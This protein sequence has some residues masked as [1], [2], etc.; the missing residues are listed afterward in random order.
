M[1]TKTDWFAFSFVAEHGTCLFAFVRI[2]QL[3]RSHLNMKANII[4]LKIPEFSQNYRASN[5]IR[6]NIVK[7]IYFA[8]GWL[9]FFFHSSSSSHSTNLNC[10]SK[11][12]NTENRVS[13]EMFD[14]PFRLFELHTNCDVC[15]KMPSI[16]F[17][18]VIWIWQCIYTRCTTCTNISWNKKQLDYR[19]VILH[20]FKRL[21]SERKGFYFTKLYQNPA[22][23]EIQI[24]SCFHHSGLCLA[25][26]LVL[27][28]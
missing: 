6:W 4:G 21:F 11:R 20:G 17:E 12:R 3:K 7:S 13:F 19:I 2:C 15:V 23:N 18:F 10:T 28:M 8:N 1:E 27:F 24:C 16:E 14:L 5:G 22:L 9:R 26:R 25:D